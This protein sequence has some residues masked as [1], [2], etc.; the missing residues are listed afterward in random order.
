ME[1]VVRAV[2]SGLV[3][4]PFDPG[5]AARFFDFMPYILHLPCEAEAFLVKTPKRYFHQLS[6]WLSCHDAPSLALGGLFLILSLHELR[7]SQIF[8]E[9]R[10]GHVRLASCSHKA[11]LKRG[12]HL[13]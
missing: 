5:A 13:L 12:G 4:P 8:S 1:G 11:S 10:A 6:L 9:V 3:L 2:R 7:I